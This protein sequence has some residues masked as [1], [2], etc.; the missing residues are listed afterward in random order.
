MSASAGKHL[1]GRAG[2][3]TGGAGPKR[4]GQSRGATCPGEL[5]GELTAGASA[6]VAPLPSSSADPG[7]LLDD[8]FHFSVFF[9]LN[10]ISF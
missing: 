2:R 5:P 7:E 9:F 3:R 4:N 10:F 6:C 1:G 8:F